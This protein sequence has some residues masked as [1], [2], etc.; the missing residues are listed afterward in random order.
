MTIVNLATRRE[1]RVSDDPPLRVLGRRV[2]LDRAAAAA[3]PGAAA[4]RSG[5]GPARPAARRRP[6]RA[7]RSRPIV[8]AA[9]ISSCASSR[10][11]RSSTSATSPTS[12][13]ART[14]TCSRWTIDAQD[15]VGNGVQLRDMTPGHG[16]RARQRQRVLRAA[17]V[18]ARRAT[19]SSVLKGTDDRALRDKRYAVARLHRPRRRRAAEGRL[20]SRGRQDV[21]RGHDDQPEPR[22]AVDRRSAGAALRHPRRRAQRDG[23]TR[24]RRGRRRARE[25]MTRRDPRTPPTR[26]RRSRT[27]RSISCC[28]T[29]RTA[30]AVAAGS[31]GGA[32][33][34]VQLPRRVP[35]AAEEVHPARRRRPAHGDGRAEAERSRS[36]SDDR[37]YELIGNL[38]G[39]RF[40][41]IFAIDLTT[42]A[43]KLALKRAALVQRPVA[44]R[45]E[46]PLLRGRQL[47]RLLDG[48]RAGHATSPQGLPISF[49][50]IE[51][52]H[53]VVKPPAGAIG[54]AKRQQHRCCSP[55][56]GTSGR[57]RSTAAPAVNLTVNGKQ[58]SRSATSAASRSSRRRARRRH[59]PREA[60]VLRRLRRVDEEGGHRAARAGQAGREDAHVV[61]RVV[62]HADRRP[63]N[64]DAYVYTRATATEPT[65][66]YVAD[67]SFANGDAADRPASAGRRSS[68]GRAGV[69]LVNYTSDK[70]DKL[71]ARALPAGQLREGQVVSDVVNIY[72]KMSQSAN[73]FANPTA[74]GFNRSLYTSNGYA[75]FAPDITYK[76]QR[77]RACRRCGAWCRR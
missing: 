76:R 23:A 61:R 55:T 51:D 69:Q 18:D 17:R 30:P 28:G 38:D 5:R 33:S 4:R 62:R 24:R 29:G 49:V 2:D 34:R 22:P 40:Q 46:V 72:E 36:A 14:A 41:D 27:R 25:A 37:E 64:A 15:K 42:G 60:A 59:R 53:N 9:P 56:T 8:R 45:Q 1:A 39:R 68:R 11:V 21:S 20:R 19:R 43:R 77:S 57:S 71:Q 31:A 47:P 54:W 26:R 66:F 48:D 10:A 7:G 44:R 13:S 16:R 3:G 73:Q 12:P 50:D 70:G 52:D 35:R 67:A 58:G 6:A 74:N 63:K 65:D 32:R 75:V